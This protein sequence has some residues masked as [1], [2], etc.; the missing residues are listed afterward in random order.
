MEAVG[1]VGVNADLRG[2]FTYVLCLWLFLR[3]IHSVL[4]LTG[5]G[6]GKLHQSRFYQATNR[7]ECGS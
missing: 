1:D 2:S 6:R 3:N 5:P 7:M 4:L